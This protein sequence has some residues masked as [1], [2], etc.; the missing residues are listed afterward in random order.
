MG[1]NHLRFLMTHGDNTL[2][3]FKTTK[4]FYINDWGSYNSFRNPTK[5][6]D[7]KKVYLLCAKDI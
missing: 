4:W 6:R 5:Q 7:A 2:N 3:S 1:I